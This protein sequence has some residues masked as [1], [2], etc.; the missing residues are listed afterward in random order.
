MRHEDVIAFLRTFSYDDEKTKLSQ[1][2]WNIRLPHTTRKERLCI[3]IEAALFAFGRLSE[4]GN[5]YSYKPDILILSGEKI[6]DKTKLRQALCVY[7]YESLMYSLG[8]LNIPK[9]FCQNSA[10]TLDRLVY[11]LDWSLEV[12]GIKL[13]SIT[14]LNPKY[15]SEIRRTLRDAQ[16][17]EQTYL[18]FSELFPK[19]SFIGYDH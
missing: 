3:S 16:T 15:S 8:I 10:D 1:P 9:G 12:N 6:D 18:T 17:D 11:E 14:H 13:Q 4:E 7:E 5:R 2:H 19:G